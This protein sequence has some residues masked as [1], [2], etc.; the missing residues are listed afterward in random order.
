MPSKI[1]PQNSIEVTLKQYEICVNMADKISQ[2]RADANKFYSVLIT[3]FF[4]VIVAIFKGEIFKVDNLPVILLVGLIGILLCV[5][6]FFNINS[7]KTLNSA[8]FKVI[9][10]MEAMLPQ[11]PFNKEWEES[12]KGKNSKIHRTLTSIEKFVPAIL[13]LPF[14]IMFFYPVYK[15]VCYGIKLLFQ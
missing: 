14:A 4:A 8:K 11:Q 6:W 7:Y 12:G 10:D 2:R 9:N 3:S 15:Y 13:G 1:T 5:V